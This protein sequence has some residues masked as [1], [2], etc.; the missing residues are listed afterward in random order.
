MADSGAPRNVVNPAALTVAEKR[1]Y[2]LG[3][4]TFASSDD[5]ASPPE[6]AIISEAA[7]RLGGRVHS[8]D[9]RKYD[10]AGIA[11]S[12]R[13]PGVRSAFFADIVR[14]AAA[15]RRWDPRELRVVKYF[16]GEWNEPLP[17]VS[18]VDWNSVETLAGTDLQGASTSQREAIATRQK[19]LGAAAPSFLWAYAVLGALVLMGAFMLFPLVLACI[20]PAL[21]AILAESVA[22]LDL[23]GILVLVFLGFFSGLVVARASPGSTLTEPVVGAIIPIALLLLATFRLLTKL[24]GGIAD[25]PGTY[26]AIAAAILFGGSLVGAWLGEMVQEAAAKPDPASPRA[27]GVRPAY[28][29]LGAI[30]Y[31]GVV[32]AFLLVGLIIAPFELVELLSGFAGTLVAACVISLVSG[33]VVAYLS[34]GETVLEPALGTL[35]PPALL[36]L[37]MLRLS[38]VVDIPSMSGGAIAQT[39][40]QVVVVFCCSFGGAALGEAMQRAAQN[41]VR[42]VG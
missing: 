18:G 32:G 38:T 23:Q 36:V 4:I 8:K 1:S 37:L 16:A 28:V 35:V 5:G 29:A 6:L 10:L 39:V 17:E 30:I 3:L 7:K 15:D 12:I 25:V 9:I 41:P 33:V 13:T 24:G 11:R 2:L 19:A 31:L 26:L 27:S 42:R 14:L 22:A 40:I 20:A 21:P 34:P